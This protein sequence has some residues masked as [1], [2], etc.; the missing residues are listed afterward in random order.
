[1]RRWCFADQDADNP[2]SLHL[3]Q[4]IWVVYLSFPMPG[5]DDDDTLT[6]RCLHP[7]GHTDGQVPT[8]TY[9]APSH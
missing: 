7:D 2:S 6:D 5:I 8:L 4:N 9:S 3:L 1:M